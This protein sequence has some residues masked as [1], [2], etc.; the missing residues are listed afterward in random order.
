MQRGRGM[1]IEDTMV[2]SVYAGLPEKSQIAQ[3]N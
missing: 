1:F 3:P 2:S